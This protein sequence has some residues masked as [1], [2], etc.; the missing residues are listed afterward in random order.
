MTTNE[1][2]ARLVE[3]CR[4]GQFDAAQKELFASDA[5]SIEPYATP[6]FEKETK[7]MEAIQQKGEKWA[8]MVQEMQ[9][10]SVSDPL[11][12]TNSFACTIH[13]QVIMKEGG[14]M[15]MTELCLYQ[16]KNGKIV[17]EEFFI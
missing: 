15:D 14:K 11:V 13:M 5:I 10:I 3:L 17:S 2:A 6:A 16:V 12:A 8:A 1:I 9:G 4:Q 7:G